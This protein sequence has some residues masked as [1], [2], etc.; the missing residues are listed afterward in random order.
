MFSVL[1]QFRDGDEVL[2][3]A[4]DIQW[5]A[6]VLTV[7]DNEYQLVRGDVA[8]VMNEY[9]ATVRKYGGK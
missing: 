7:G 1:I 4:E 3:A 6:G 2:D 8:Y 9:G 5:Y